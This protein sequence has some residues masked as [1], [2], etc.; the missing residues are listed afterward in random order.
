MAKPR[1]KSILVLCVDRDN[2]IGEVTGI[3]TPLIGEN[4]IR[5]AAMEFAS[6]R[7]EDSDVNAVF[8]AVKLYSDLMTRKE[9]ENIDVALVAGHKEEGVKA[10]VRI[11]EELDTILSERKYDGVIL[12]SDGPTDELVLPLIQSK[13][14][15]LSVQRVV[16]QQSRGVEES[17]LL[18]L[19]Y[20]KR[21]FEEEKYKKYALGVPGALL[22]LYIFLSFTIP[23]FVWPLILLALGVTMLVKGFSLDESMMKV[24]RSSP[25]L[26]TALIASAM[27]I[28][29]AFA[30][31]F[32][33][34]NSLNNVELFKATGYF[35]LAS[36]GDQVLVLDLL[37]IAFLLPLAAQ[38][39][40]AVL[41][42]GHF[43]TR[44][45]VAVILL[46]F[47]RQVLLEYAKL[48]VGAGSIFTLL[49]WVIVSILALA[50]AAALLP[51]LARHAKPSPK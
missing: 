6:R 44:E 51:I 46:V 2:D 41:G 36:L 38:A 5:Q 30:T 40:E 4:R 11:L 10:D 19:R 18:L 20:A 37:F 27:I 48:L 28:A 14:P 35:L 9:F 39:T 16:V 12:V 15:V 17:F 42:T 26:F 29:L 50:I 7:P 33:S 13:L 25:M 1:P 31:G 21:L 49:L 43:S 23:G 34:V 3:S 24:Y 32:S 45:A 22:T 8:A 47:L